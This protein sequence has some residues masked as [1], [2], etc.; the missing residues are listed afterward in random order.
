M[1]LGG[2]SR[3]SAGCPWDRAGWAEGWRCLCSRAF[4][5]PAPGYPRFS[6]SLASTFLP[7]S[8]LDHHGNSNVLY[9]QH[10]F[11]GAQKG[12]CRRWGSWELG[13]RPPG[14]GGLASLVHPPPWVWRWGVGLRSRTQPGAG[15]AGLTGRTAVRSEPLPFLALRGRPAPSAPRL[16]LQPSPG[17]QGRQ[18][19]GRP[20]HPAS[21]GGTRSHPTAGPAVRQAAKVHV[22]A[23]ACTYMCMCVLGASLLQQTEEDLSPVGRRASGGV[24]GGGC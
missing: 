11:Y 21:V 9:G 16:A 4:A 20:A 6:G 17:P 19:S 12:R 10:R 15:S 24:S 18:G 23:H 14:G 8:H 5:S 2:C 3:G 1:A 22:C 13:R 7:M